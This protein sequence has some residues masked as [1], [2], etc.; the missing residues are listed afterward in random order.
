[1]ALLRLNSIKKLIE[2]QNSTAAPYPTHYPLW[3]SASSDI[4]LLY[5]GQ[6]PRE[7][8]ASQR[9]VT[10]QQLQWIDSL[11]SRGKIKTVFNT[12]LFFNG[13]SR[14]PEYAGI[15][16]AF[17][18]SL[19]SLFVC[20]ILSFPIGVAAAL[21]LEEFAPKNKITELIEININNLAAVP[22]SY[23][24]LTLPTKA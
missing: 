14:N 21:Y 3:V 2:L 9:R 23:T 11:D 8:D 13:D 10:D 22:V 4:D 16:G 15:A 19:Y 24:H 18:G 12:Y 20:F 1:M 17:I 6:V 5:K 7:W